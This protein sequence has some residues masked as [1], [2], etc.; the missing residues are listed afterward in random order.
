VELVLWLDI[1]AFIRAVGERD[2]DPAD[3]DNHV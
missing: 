1:D 2:G 3:A